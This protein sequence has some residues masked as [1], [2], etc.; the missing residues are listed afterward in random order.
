MNESRSDSSTPSSS[1]IHCL[2]AGPQAYDRYSCVEIILIDRHETEGYEIIEGEVKAT[3]NGVTLGV[4]NIQFRGIT[5][6]ITPTGINSTQQKPSARRWTIAA[7]PAGNCIITHSVSSQRFLSQQARTAPT[8][9]S[10][11]S[12]TRSV[13][14]WNNDYLHQCSKQ[15]VEEAKKHRCTPYRIR[16]RG[17]NSRSHERWKEIPAVKIQRV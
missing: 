11:P 4:P 13:S 9:R 1:R 3:D 6:C 5:R 7:I 2:A 10:S 16:G 17:A 8:A 14:R 12:E 15:L